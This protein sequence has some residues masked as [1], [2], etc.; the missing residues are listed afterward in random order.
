MNVHNYLDICK[1][2]V[3]KSCINIRA[4]FVVPAEDEAMRNA[5]NDVER[6]SQLIPHAGLMSETPD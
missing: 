2:N 3:L 6:P 4:K 1:P 5:V